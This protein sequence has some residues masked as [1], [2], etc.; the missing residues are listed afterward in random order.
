MS[1]HPW[2]GVGPK[3]AGVHTAIADPLVGRLLEGRYRI[4]SQLARGGMSTVYTAIDERLDRLVAVKVMSPALSADPSFTDRFTREARS[5]AKLTHTNAV[6]VYDQGE[7]SGKNGLL[8]F[9]VMELV[10][11]RTLR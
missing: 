5:A 8:V 1:N 2:A 9:L 6:A 3:L 10:S 7:E 4:Q 11:G